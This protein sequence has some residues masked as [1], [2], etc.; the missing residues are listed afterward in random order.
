MHNHRVPAGVEKKTIKLIEN[1]ARVQGGQI[2]PARL[3]LFFSPGGR[4]HNFKLILLP[5]EYIAKS[6]WTSKRIKAEEPGDLFVTETVILF[7]IVSLILVCL[8]NL[9][10]IVSDFVIVSLILVCTYSD[11][12]CRVQ[13]R[14]ME[15]LREEEEKEARWAL[16]D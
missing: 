11:L 7:V 2:Q 10:C 13:S 5:F 16:I 8:S 9:F 4:V 15:R 1:R 14:D 6:A 12:F 3:D